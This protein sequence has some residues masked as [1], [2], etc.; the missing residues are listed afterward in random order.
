MEKECNFY[1]CCKR[2]KYPNFD[3]WSMFEHAIR[4]VLLSLVRWV[5][6]IQMWLKTNKYLILKYPELRNSASFSLPRHSHIGGKNSTATWQVFF[7]GLFVARRQLSFCLW[8]FTPCEFRTQI[9]FKNNISSG[10]KN[11]LACTW[12]ISKERTW[13][14]RFLI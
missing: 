3:E 8:L 9:L 1:F 13:T 6:V 14:N 5:S 2:Q 12:K 7:K 10:E 11:K 4:K